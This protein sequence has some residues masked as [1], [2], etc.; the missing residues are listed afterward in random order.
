MTKHIAA[1]TTLAFFGFVDSGGTLT[2]ESTSAPAVNVLS[3]MRRL[4]GIQSA[5]PGIP[6]GEDVVIEGDDGALGTI[7]FA[8][9][10]TPAFVANFGAA[11]LNTEAALQQ[12]SVWSLGG[13]EI[14]ALQPE[15]PGQTNGC[16]II[17]GKS[18]SKDDGT[19]GNSIWSGIILPFVSTQV[20]GRETFEGRTAAAYR[21]KFTAQIAAHHP[22]GI[23]I[24]ASNLGTTGASIL[25]FEGD[26][27]MIMD[28]FT[29]NGAATSVTLTKQV[30][31]TDHIAAVVNT[32]VLTHGAGITATANSQTL[33]F[34]SAPASNAKVVIIYGFVP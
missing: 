11:D 30:A 8:P 20:L 32:Q 4:L 26:H 31:A 28:R 10:T 25:P 3:P 7:T 34:S 2:G 15:D 1:G 33:T 24:T 14:G 6:E 29:G 12:T 19:S 18:V 16:L 9:N 23:T 13:Y 27:P 22:S 21:L 5:S 17:Q